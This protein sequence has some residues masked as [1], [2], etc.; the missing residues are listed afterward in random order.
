M[1]PEQARGK[2]VDK[3]ADIWAFGVLLWEMLSGQR[4]FVGETVSASWPRC[5]RAS[6]TFALCWQTKAETEQKQKEIERKRAKL[7]A[8]VVPQAPLSAASCSPASTASSPC[9]TRPNSTS[10]RRSSPWAPSRSVD[11]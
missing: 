1:S 9:T 11:G 3:R 4:L 7:Y 5:S 10:T 6:P 8:D 2:G